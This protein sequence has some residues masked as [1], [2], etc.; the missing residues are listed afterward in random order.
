MSEVVT[1]RPP[2]EAA[3]GAVLVVVAHPDDETL[4]AGATIHRLA[5]SGLHVHV[6]VLSGD[7]SARNFRP[8]DA[9]LR[10][11]TL[12][13]LKRLGV[14]SVQFGDF[15]NIQMNT[16]PHLALV[17]FIEGA[18][19]RVSASTLITHHPGDINDDHRQVSAACQAAARLPQRRTGA[20]PLRDLMYME[21]LSSTDW[22]FGDDQFRP[23]LFQEL[24]EEDVEAKID[25]L[26][27]YRDVMR[28]HPHPRSRESIT[29]LSVLRGSQCGVARAE[30]FA[31][32]H[33]LRREPRQW[34]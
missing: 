6:C 5:R 12:S 16:V 18:I 4:G 3:G 13:A 7:V 27:Q 24:D 15:P 34:S 10:H 17:Q 8:D 22:A 11:D 28:P 2:V 9:L 26:S 23:T 19:E 25:A 14:I 29:A 33:A 30:A 1:L 21:V 32:V 31:S 20:P